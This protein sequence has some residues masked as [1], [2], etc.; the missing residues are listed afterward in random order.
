MIAKFNVKKEIKIKNWII[1]ENAGN[2][3]IEKLIS[4]FNTGS[5]RLELGIANARDQIDQALVKQNDKKMQLKSCINCMI[6]NLDVK[7][8]SGIIKD[9]ISK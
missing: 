6:F 8:V 7:K 3:A 5:K 9:I 2:L 4:V 1:N